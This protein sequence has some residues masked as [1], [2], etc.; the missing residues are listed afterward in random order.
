MA[1]YVG[2]HPAR[3]RKA[4]E[5]KVFIERKRTAAYCQ[6]KPVPL[7]QAVERIGWGANN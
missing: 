2:A 5:R 1:C 3:E 7:A 6:G 4:K